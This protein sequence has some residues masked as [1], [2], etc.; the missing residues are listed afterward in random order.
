MSGERME[1]WVRERE[2]EREN[3]MYM[4]LSVV[5]ACAYSQQLAQQPL[6]VAALWTLPVL[7]LPAKHSHRV[8]SNTLHAL[9][10]LIPRP[11]NG[12]P[13][14]TYHMGDITDVI[15]VGDC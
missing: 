14:I 6:P 5:M 7:S 11:S 13:G 8:S 4:Y 15:D 3:V 1:D 9:A 12:R 10:S 2:R